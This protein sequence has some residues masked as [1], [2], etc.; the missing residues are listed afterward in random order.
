MAITHFALT[1]RTQTG[2]QVAQRAVQYLLRQ[3]PYAPTP[4]VVAQRDRGARIRDTAVPRH[5][6][7]LVWQQIGN[8]PVWAQG[9]AVRF[10]AAAVAYERTNGR[11]GMALQAALPREL[12]RAQQI[13]LTQNF[14]QAHLPDKPYLVVMH[15]PRTATGEQQQHIHVLF[16]ERQLDGIARTARQF[17]KRANRDH[18]E[19]GGAAKDL[20]WHERRCPGRL[21]QAWVD[22]SS[23]D[24]RQSRRLDWDP[25]KGG[26]KPG[27]A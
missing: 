25:L 20:F 2:T 8:L 11:W 24:L 15:E 27:A 4:D 14:I 5:R 6:D 9:N 12:T 23:H 3:G 7:D 26:H 22:L 17:F 19:R 21:R 18:P 13:A 1:A 16:S 10:F